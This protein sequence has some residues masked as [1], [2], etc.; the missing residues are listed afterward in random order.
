VLKDDMLGYW[1]GF[2]GSHHPGGFDREHT[3]LQV[4]VNEVQE[5][6]SSSDNGKKAK[7]V[8]FR[9]IGEGMQTRLFLVGEVFEVGLL[10]LHFFFSVCY[11]YLSSRYCTRQ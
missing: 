9:G 7:G 3:I 5:F 11:T 10:V 2:E 8:L 6:E 1:Y 4:R